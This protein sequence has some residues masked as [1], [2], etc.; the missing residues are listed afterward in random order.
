[1]S[2]GNKLGFLDSTKLYFSWIFDCVIRNACD[3][4]DRRNNLLVDFHHSLVCQWIFIVEGFIVKRVAT[5]PKEPP[6]L[7]VA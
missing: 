6:F 4:L 7:G 2:E 3:K 5:H 1:M